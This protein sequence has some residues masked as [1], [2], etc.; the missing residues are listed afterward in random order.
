MNIGIGFKYKNW[1]NF[2]NI[3]FKIKEFFRELKYGWQRFWDGYDA[4]EVFCMNDM[5]RY[6][7]INILNRYK[8]NSISSW[9]CPEGYELGEKDNWANM[10]I[11]TDEQQEAIIDTMI[12]HLNMTDEDYVIKMKYGID[13]EADDYLIR[14]CELKSKEH[15]II[16]SVMQQNARLF[17]KLFDMFYF[18][19]WD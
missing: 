2:S 17:F 8:K 10:Y 13:I 18:Q 1:N 19:L 7:Y 9:W 4:R 6:R 3:K 5:F 11:L 15:E 14:I 16:N 12:H